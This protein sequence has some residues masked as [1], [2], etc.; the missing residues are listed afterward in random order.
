MKNLI[1][2]VPE[3]D[4]NLSSIVG[5][6]KIFKR[7]NEYWEKLGKG[8][9]FNIQLAGTSDVVSFHDEWFSVHPVHLKK[10]R[11][12]DL[13]IIPSLNHN[14]EKSIILNMPLIKWIKRKYDGGS[15]VASICTG[16]FLLAASGI[17]NG[18]DCSTHLAAQDD[19]RRMFP[20]VNL[21]YDKIITDQHGI[22]TN[23]GAFSFLNL[24]IYLIEKYFDRRTAMYCAKTFQ[25]DIDR[26]SQSPFTIFSNLKNHE[27]HEVHQAQLIIEKA[28]HKKINIEEISSRLAIGRRSFDRRFVKATGETPVQYF[29]RAKVEAAK[30][31][32]E[33]DR[34]S[35]QEIMYN[36]GYT[37]MKAFRIIFKRVTGLSPLDYRKKFNHANLRPV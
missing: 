18:K 13:I 8:S 19:F 31:A 12:A 9:M 4:N 33:Q 25:I 24:I 17:I 26:N 22:Y 6:Y 23:G 20:D 10:I 21:V 30:R 15:E 27:D 3:G 14:F 29:H 1:I 5:S 2:L 11:K 32:L 37:D 34:K 35:V 28:I 36:V 7:A 16:A